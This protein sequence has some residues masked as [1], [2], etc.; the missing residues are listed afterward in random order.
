MNRPNPRRTH[1]SQPSFRHSAVAAAV[2]LALATPAYSNPSGMSVVAGQ[3]TMTQMGNLTQITNT[4]GAILN[5]QQF[6]IDVGQ[7]TQFIQQSANSQVFNRVTGGDVSQIL[8]TL[9]SN[10]QVFLINPAGVFFGA[11][12]VI[13]TA[14]F[15]ASSLAASNTDLLNGHLKFSA[16]QGGAGSIV[17]QGLLKSHSGGSIVLLAPSIENSG[18]IHAQGEVLLAAGHSVTIVDMRHPTIGLT[19]AAKEGERALNLGQLIG[20]NASLFGALVQNTGVVEATGVEAGPGGV[21][22]FVGTRGAQ[23]DAGS[24]ALANGSSGGQVHVSAG[25]GDA[26]VAGQV[27]ANGEQG[28]G[29][30]VTVTGERVAVLSGATV[31]A[32]GRDGGGTV[33]LGGGW[34]G[35]NPALQNAQHTV[36][37]AGA[38][39]SANANQQGRGGEVVAWAD[40]HT[41]VD[42][43][44]QAKGGA[45][46]GDGGRVET[47][48]KQS[49]DV[50][51][52]A[53]TSAP[54]GKAGQWL[55][56]PAN[57]TVVDQIPPGNS[58]L[59]AMGQGPFSYSSDLSSNPESYLLNTTVVDGLEQNGFV[60]IYTTGSSPGE[61]N[62]TIAAPVLVT[63]NLSEFPG[64]IPELV[65]EAQGTINI[66]APVGINPISTA[67]DGFR[68]TLNYDIAKP[69][70]VDAPLYLG[71]GGLLT[72]APYDIGTTLPVSTPGQLPLDGVN[73]LSG[74][75][76]ADPATPLSLPAIE[77]ADFNPGGS[78]LSS[79]APTIP[80]GTRVRKL[81][82]LGANLAVQTIDSFGSSTAPVE[83]NV[84][85]DTFELPSPILGS[86]TYEFLDA[87]SLNIKD[88]ASATA[89]FLN[90]GAAS[91][92]LNTVNV[93][94]RYNL[95]GG[96]GFIG[97]LNLNSGNVTIRPLNDPNFSSTFASYDIAQL[98]TAAGTQFDVSGASL[99]YG[100]GNLNGTMDVL[101]DAFS[102]QSAFVS[103]YD[104]N[105][106]G[107][108]N[109]RS[110]FNAIE[111]HNLGMGSASVLRI[112]EGSFVDLGKSFSSFASTLGPVAAK[113]PGAYISS[114]GGQFVAASGARIDMVGTSTIAP[115]VNPVE[116]GGEIQPAEISPS[117]SFGPVGATL[118]LTGLD[119]RLEAPVNIQV[120]GLQNQIAVQEQNFP[121]DSSG[122]GTPINNLLISGANITVNAGQD[123]RSLRI[124]QYEFSQSLGMRPP[125]PLVGVDFRGNLTVNSGRVRL[126]GSTVS[127]TSGQLSVNGAGSALRLDGSFTSADLFVVNRTNGGRLAATGLWNNSAVTASNASTASPLTKGTIFVNDDLTIAGGYLGSGS[128]AGN[129]NVT[130]DG[131][132]ELQGTELAT[133]VDLAPEAAL[134]LAAQDK[135]GATVAPV[136]MNNA[137]INFGGDSFLV[138]ETDAQGNGSITGTAT[139]NSATQGNAILAGRRVFDNAQL[140]A[141]PDAANLTIGQGITINV[142]GN[143]SSL[144]EG[145]AFYYDSINS[146]PDTNRPV[147]RIGQLTTEMVG[148]IEYDNFNGFSTPATT[149]LSGFA[150]PSFVVDGNP[151]SSIST[152][153]C[154]AL[155]FCVKFDVVQTVNFQGRITSVLNQSAPTVA[156]SGVAFAE[157]TNLAAIRYQIENASEIRFV[158]GQNQVNLTDLA[159]GKRVVNGADSTLIFA[160]NGANQAL[161]NEMDNNG[162]LSLQGNYTFN[163]LILGT[164]S[165]NNS[166]NLVLGNG[167]GSTVSNS[168][169]NT[170]TVTNQG[171][172]RFATL[173]SG[174]GSLINNG[175][176][177]FEG[178]GSFGNNL[179]NGAASTLTFSGASPGQNIQFNNGFSNA[180]NVQFNPGSFAFLTGFNQSGGTT[181]V[182]PGTTLAGA[183]NIN[184]GTLR[185]FATISGNLNAAGGRIVPGASPGLMTVNGDLNL[186]ANSVLDIEIQ[187][188]GGVQGVDY[189]C[190][191]VNGNANLAGQ[192]NLIDISG[193]T[194]GAGN[195]Y[196][197]LTAN[198]I[199]GSFGTITKT[200]TPASYAFADP[201]VFG[202]T[203]GQLLRTSTFAVQPPPPPPPP[204]PQTTPTTSPAPSTLTTSTGGS[205]S[206]V[207]QNLNQA[208]APSSSTSTSGSTGSTSRS[209]S[210]TTSS[211]PTQQEETVTAANQ[212]TGDTTTSQRSNDIQMTQTKSNPTRA[213]AVCK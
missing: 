63:N 153:T 200:G 48:G 143:A 183:I 86:L 90:F 201:A 24:S 121:T 189:D 124:G 127:T 167:N 66:D 57:L 123:E 204:P 101:Q 168:L 94:G 84:G 148:L 119:G 213:A 198:A 155:D 194:L 53:N 41:R 163:G 203:N 85:A 187:S 135:N 195:N 23:L 140:D 130:S 69:V 93:E 37:Q 179:V 95:E 58:G 158:S 46:G 31:Q 102:G 212:S 147:F 16:E 25:Q 208:F 3:A 78:P 165:I 105:L 39:V 161:S 129:I 61:G 152:P 35:K 2:A 73:L 150:N 5:W 160:A 83:V 193:G 59:E 99:D 118:D 76:S 82:I 70:Y 210:T 64:A 113:A 50:R 4:P 55:L 202:A 176:L 60:Q 42:S 209:G 109:V 111:L 199:A 141:A 96:T 1:S 18:I 185:G 80:D 196:D 97:S 19:V 115:P 44:L 9:Q 7:T 180:G 151:D 65:L 166:G 26:V 72:L 184:G 14:G 146:A 29:G 136:V 15:L 186:N 77:F 211:S 21:I 181:T 74:M 20:Q 125:P 45:L 47:S 34:Q 188:N 149:V 116:F 52:A 6:N 164:G 22:R 38:S 40:G 100:V 108:I 170:G 156:N 182:Q 128:S 68:L 43:S 154:T 10:G 51:A 134:L 142:A 137:T 139:F 169:S 138:V 175:S 177:I 117:S 133:R 110:G 144:P 49:L 56:D 126:T 79:Q 104:T 132:L 28:Q 191:V 159:S 103:G 98:N 114:T 145:L 207:S 27:Q 106:F 120:S 75:N 174:S 112:E 30:T 197:F 71:Q 92:F 172:Y 89:R 8:G 62:L 107:A 36:V 17:N 33:H 162:T 206:Q 32:D 54:K 178:S 173:P 131:F 205:G 88:G 87:D 13:D 67:F 171:S 91:T 192:L 190:I 12:A 81:N 157:G 11:G 122:L